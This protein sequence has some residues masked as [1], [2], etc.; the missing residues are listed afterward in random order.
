MATTVDFH[1]GVGDVLGF[2]CRLLRKACRK[3]VPVVVIAGDATLQALD[4]ALWTFEERDFLPHVVVD[5]PAPQ[6]AATA[7]R[8][9]T[10]IWLWRGGA[11]DA[12]HPRVLVS[13]GADAL[14][15]AS[16]FDRVIEVVSAD[17]DEAA[18]GR[19]RWRAWQAAGH[20]VTHRNATADRD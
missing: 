4:R 15:L 3:G 13:L 17:P 7:V 12:G 1:T 5:G 2:A 6:G 9:R 20:E 11:L 10:P 14:S 8:G 19:R 18:A 16:V